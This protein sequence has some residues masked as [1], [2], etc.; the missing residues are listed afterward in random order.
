[1]PL[2]CP[3]EEYARLTKAF[4]AEESDC[5]TDIGHFG[6]NVSQFNTGKSFWCSIAKQLVTISTAAHPAPRLPK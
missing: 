1:M 4:P 6:S 5:A 2:A 3:C